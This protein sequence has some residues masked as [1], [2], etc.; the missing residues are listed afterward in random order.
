MNE[1]LGNHGCGEA[2]G[3]LRRFVSFE[4]RRGKRSGQGQESWIYVVSF[5]QNIFK[6]TWHILKKEAPIKNCC[7]EAGKI[8]AKRF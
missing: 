2:A 4:N 3:H 5:Q 1:L 7:I 6:I 8:G